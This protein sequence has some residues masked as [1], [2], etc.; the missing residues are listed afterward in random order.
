MITFF[1]HRCEERS[2]EKG[3]ELIWEERAKKGRRERRQKE[4][5]G[6]KEEMPIANRD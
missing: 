5:R 3:K 6:E 2:R 4:G 1:S